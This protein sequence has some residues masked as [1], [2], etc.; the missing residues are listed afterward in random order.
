MHPRN[1]KTNNEVDDQR[2]CCHLVRQV[3]NRDRSRDRK[4]S[5]GRQGKPLG[6]AFVK[7]KQPR[8]RGTHPSNKRG[9]R[10]TF[11]PIRCVYIYGY[12]FASLLLWP[13]TPNLSPSPNPDQGPSHTRTPRLPGPKSA[14]L[15]CKNWAKSVPGL[16]VAVEPRRD[17]VRYR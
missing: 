16:A 3:Q 2:V 4:V 17:Y 6:V 9:P 5:D 14:R 10:C 8:G 15:W 1:N 13:T 11:L 12:I 7:Q